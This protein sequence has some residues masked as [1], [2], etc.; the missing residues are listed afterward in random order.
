LIAIFAG[1]LLPLIF[2]FVPETAFR[3]DSSF[4]TDLIGE[5]SVQHTIQTGRGHELSANGTPRDG[6]SPDASG[7]VSFEKQ[8]GKIGK[9]RLTQ[10]GQDAIP[11]RVSFARSLMPFNGRKTDESFLKLLFRPLPLFFHPAI[12]WACLIQGTLIGWTVMIGVVLAA[13]FL[14]PP[15]SIIFIA[16]KRLLITC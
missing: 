4:N 8:H 7:P 14:G 3:R 16:R 5:D 2:L 6:D 15:V 9:R 1:A 11:C 12:F 13:I 10:Q